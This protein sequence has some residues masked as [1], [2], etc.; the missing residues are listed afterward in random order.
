MSE[1]RDGG[2]AG[3]SLLA[4]ILLIS[5]TVILCLIYAELLFLVGNPDP[6]LNFSEGVK[7]TRSDFSVP[8]PSRL[9]RV[10]D[11]D[12][13]VADIY[14]PAPVDGLFIARRIRILGYDAPEITRRGGA[15]EDDVKRGIAARE[16]LIGWLGDQ[17]IFIESKGKDSFGRELADVFVGERRES[18]RDFMVK[19]GHV[20]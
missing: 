11:G 15:T 19:N 20:K 1:I 13:L 9:V 5:H 14:V 8:L 18:V 7:A 2:R 17:D 16:A 10:I 4:F 3:V 12:T 6:E